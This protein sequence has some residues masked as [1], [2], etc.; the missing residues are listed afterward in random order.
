MNLYAFKNV[1]LTELIGIIFDLCISDCLILIK[2][3][4]AVLI[5]FCRFF[6]FIF[7]GIALDFKWVSISSI[8]LVLGLVLG[9]DLVLVL[10]LG[11]DLVLVLAIYTDCLPPNRDINRFSL[12]EIKSFVYIK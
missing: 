11:S 8:G 6:A 4:K 10:V 7:V 3:D 9:S 2:I 5:I 12:N 1:G